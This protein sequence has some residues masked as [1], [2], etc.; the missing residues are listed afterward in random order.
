MGTSQGTSAPAERCGE[1]TG[2][3]SKAVGSDG[4]G[5]NFDFPTSPPCDLVVVIEPSSD[6]LV[7]VMNSAGCLGHSKCPMHTSYSCAGVGGDY[8]H[9]W[10]SVEGRA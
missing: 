1:C 8:Y 3:Q 9:F 7:H 6:D 10:N 5:S 4:L 2:V